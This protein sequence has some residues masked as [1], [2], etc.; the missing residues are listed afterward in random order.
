M[1]PKQK[2]AKKDFPSTESSRTICVVKQPNPTQNRTSLCRSSKPTR[3]IVS[4]LHRTFIKRSGNSV[5]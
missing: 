2:G 1:E 5:T 3:K 4:D